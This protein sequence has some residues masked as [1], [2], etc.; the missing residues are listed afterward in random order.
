MTGP[1]GLLGLAGLACTA[2]CLLPVLITA[3]A[4]GGTGVSIAAGW[5]P[6]LAAALAALAGEN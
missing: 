6:A 5:L 2:C 4:L 3:D 1:T